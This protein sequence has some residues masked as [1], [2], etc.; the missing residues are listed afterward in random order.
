MFAIA[1]S[2]VGSGLVMKNGAKVVRPIMLVVIVLFAIRLVTDL[3][4]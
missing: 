4:A 3:L 2:Y 1:G